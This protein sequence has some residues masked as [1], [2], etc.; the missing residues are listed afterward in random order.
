MQLYFGK[1]V[2]HNKVQRKDHTFEELIE[3]FSKPRD[4]GV[5]AKKYLNLSPAQLQA[6]KDGCY[7]CPCSFVVPKRADMNS[8]KIQLVILDIDDH[9][10]ARQLDEFTLDMR[11]SKYNYLAYST[12]SST[13]DK[14]KMRV[15][16]E[17]DGRVETELYAAAVT[18]IADKLGFEEVNKESLVVSQPMFLPKLLKGNEYVFISSNDGRA[19][20]EKDINPEAAQKYREKKSDMGGGD[21]SRKTSGDS[22]RYLELPI[23]MST[24]DVSSALAGL[25]PDTDYHT[26]V[27]IASGLSHQFQGSDE[28]LDLFDSFSSRGEKYP[29]YEAIKDKWKYC[30][31][32]PA[33]KPVT[34]RTILHMAREK[35]WKPKEETDKIAE[36]IE[37][38][39]DPDITAQQLRT[40]IPKEI[41]TTELDALMRETLIH[42][43]MIRLKELK[44]PIS[45]TAIRKAC[46]IAVDVSKVQK[47][48][49][50]IWKNTEVKKHKWSRGMV[51]VV[52]SNEFFNTK[53]HLSTSIH[54]TD[55]MYSKYL[56]TAEEQA[57][58][59]SRP[60]MRPQDYL[61]NTLQVS[62]V[63]SYVYI[64]GGEAIMNLNE[65]KLANIYRDTTPDFDPTNS[66]RVGALFKRHVHTMFPND[67]D[68]QI[69]MDFLAYTV[70]QPAKRVIWAIILQGG[71]GIGKTYLAR[72]MKGVLGNDNVGTPDNTTINKDWTDWAKGKKMIVIEEVKTSGKDRWITEGRL[73]PFISN[74]VV[75]INERFK[76]AYEIPNVTN[77][78]LLSN[79][80]DA[81]AIADND[82]RYCV[83][84][85]ILQT[86]AQ[87]E[88]I[89]GQQYFDRLFEG[90]IPY[91]G[92]LRHYLH[93]WKISKEFNPQGRAP[94]TV[95]KSVAVELS[96][97]DLRL[98]VDAIIHGDSPGCGLEVLSST[99]LAV[100]LREENLGLKF[101]NRSI[102]H[103]LHSMG[104]KPIEKRT[105]V[106]KILHTLW[107][108]EDA[109]T[110]VAEDPEIYFRNNFKEEGS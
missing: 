10:Q 6:V 72:A 14:P 90:T 88:A 87:V 22:F 32:N 39:N 103:M 52:G 26:W 45:L 3:R 71:Y 33:K 12:I 53:S 41:S 83:L 61:M 94:D 20:T 30:Y 60:E 9:D 29:G 68:A 38:I 21:H 23:S 11:L 89:G 36:L 105:K 74:D 24:E 82:R 19:F 31:P 43:V 58:G 4:A 16:V 91:P 15:M 18:T 57:L 64:P 73:K 17:S 95:H 1:S 48:E 44:Q 28:G 56:F 84:M 106:N 80:K 81:L 40:E 13:P 110:E 66:A 70:Q 8:D 75:T 78:L 96:K 97:N 47:T 107:V 65:K 67:Q 92:A 85:S 42:L 79:Y 50:G 34:I 2:F 54:Q 77:Y 86:A 69:L 51:Y 99:M 102:S 76:S 7:V 37:K 98:A 27:K 108:H 101:S 104:Y 35:G 46:A 49:E 109:S 93:N 55:L 59:K 62:I 25:D 5:T 63:D 100:M